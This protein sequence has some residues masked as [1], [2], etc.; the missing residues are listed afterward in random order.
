MPTLQR[1][2]K[3]RVGMVAP[4]LRK[5]GDAMFGIACIGV[6]FVLLAALA[7]V[8]CGIIDD[9]RADNPGKDNENADDARI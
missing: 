9:R 7:A 2:S 8:V 3:L 1:P 5:R 6:A 4:S